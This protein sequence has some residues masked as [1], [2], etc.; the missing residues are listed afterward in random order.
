MSA[1]KMKLKERSQK[2]TALE[3][4]NA[5][6]LD[7]KTEKGA[8]SQGPRRSL[9]AQESPDSNQQGSRELSVTTT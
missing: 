2:W 1:R 6:L 7:F 5:L 3:G 8:V 9:D 4:L